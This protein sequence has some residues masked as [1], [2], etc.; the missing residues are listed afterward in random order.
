MDDLKT[1]TD[2][3]WGD[4]MYLENTSVAWNL[5]SDRQLTIYGSPLT[6]QYGLSA[7]Q[8][9]VSTDI[10]SGEIPKNTD[11]L[12][13]HGPPRGHLEGMR[14]SECT[15]LAREVVR[16]WPRLV[17]YGYIHVGYGEE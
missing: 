13:T 16:V 14:K 9:L 10:W 5:P 8:Y 12:L 6:P 7:F 11:I 15:F 1:V 2:L 3:D 4:L 17:A